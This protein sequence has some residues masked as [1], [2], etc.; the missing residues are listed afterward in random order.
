VTFPVS[1][2]KFD[3]TV[4]KGVVAH[5]GSLVFEAGP[6]SVPLRSLALKSTQRHSPFSAKVGGSQ[7][8]IASVA[9]L[10]VAREGFGVRIRA[11]ALRLSAKFAERLG[12]KLRLHGAFQAG[13]PL[14]SALTRAQPVTVALENTGKV[15]FALD[16]GIAAKL[17]SLF[18]AVNPIYPA[19]HPG[20]LFTLPIFGGTIAPDASSGTLQA[21]GSLELLQLGGGQVFWQEPWL[22]LAT[23][24]LSAEVD[25]EPAPPYAGKAGRIPIAAFSLSGTAVA[26]DPSARTVSVGSIATT[27]QAS[28]AQTFN[29]VFAKPQGREGVFEAGE[30]LGTI[31]FT[32]Q[33]H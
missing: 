21:S 2:G 6:R 10:S 28:T 24:T 31:G 7:L 19:E 8:K 14:G 1:G 16:P 11:S 27:L 23:K 17:R 22:D 32:A 33:G 9:K 13:Q 4:A 18:V 3:P 5:E 29:E 30:A 26:S 25:V 20:T 15:A 12:K